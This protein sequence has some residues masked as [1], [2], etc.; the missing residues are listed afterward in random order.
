MIV[1]THPHQSLLEEVFNAVSHGFGIIFG[2]VALILLVAKA[3]L[4]E[5]I[6]QIV[7]VSVYGTTLILMY[8]A[9]TLYHALPLPKAKALFRII[10]HSTIYLLIAGTYT[11]LMLVSIGGAWGWSLFGVIWGLALIGLFY[12]SFFMGKWPAF[13]VTLYIAMGW[14]AIVAI[15]P[16]IADL[17]S[18]ALVWLIIGG[19]CYTLGV[20]FFALDHKIKFFHALWHLFVLAGSVCHFF[21]ILLYVK[22]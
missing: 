15:K 7:S 17:P 18:A 6:L 13:S 12:K 16:L 5:S 3:E 20:I 9:S 2:I 19:L 4:R 10:D 14:L 22:A 11:P 1:K 8:S 21:A